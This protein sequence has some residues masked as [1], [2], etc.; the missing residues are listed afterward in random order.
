MIPLDTE[1][2]REAAQT[3]NVAER[4]LERCGPG[5]AALG[6]RLRELRPQVVVTCAR[7]SSDHAATY[8]QYLLSTRLGIPVASMGPSVATVYGTALQLKGQL[9][10]AV[11]Q[12]GRSP[13]L[14]QLTCAARTAG[15]L[16]VALVNDEES[17]LADLAEV[18][19]PLCAGPER[20]V[21]ATKSYLTALVAFLQLAAHWSDDPALH[22]SV[23]AVPATLRAAAGLDWFP[24][25]RSLE[26]ARNMF[27]IGRGLGMGAA[28]EL[29]LKFKETCRLHAEAFS[30]AEVSHGP[31]ALAGPGFP[32]LA[33]GQD[34]R[35]APAFAELLTR[36]VGLGATV[37]V[38]G[39]APA[40]TIQL[41]SLTG[42]PAELA[43]LAAVQSF[44]LA[45]AQLAR[46]RGLDP[47]V[48]PN[49]RKVTE[50][51]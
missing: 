7:G 12:S 46:L 44:Y 42:L 38:S 33:L 26:P 41:P 31:L 16:T 5:F 20:S 30:A 49:L 34:D 36:L 6:R 39:P 10:I 40:G 13:D 45:A 17:P 8:G 2:A 25:L 48:P 19:L 29:A 35:S 15:A 27:V 24:A 21:A 4:Q 22:A 28:L 50:T 37:L 18:T 3:A 11:S 9:F 14:L 23:A 1:M 47:D 43:P 51:V 32:V